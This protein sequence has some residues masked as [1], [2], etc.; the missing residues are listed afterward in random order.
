MRFEILHHARKSNVA[1]SLPDV[2]VRKCVHR[3]FRPAINTLHHNRKGDKYSLIR[4]L[5]QP[6]DGLFPPEGPNQDPEDDQHH[7]LLLPHLQPS[8]HRPG[9][10]HLLRLRP[11]PQRD[12]QC[13]GRRHL[14]RQ[15]RRQPLHLPG[16]PVEEHQREEVLQQPDERVPA[17]SVVHVQPQEGH[18]LLVRLHFVQGAHES[19]ESAIAGEQ[20]LVGRR[21]GEQGGRNFS[22]DRRS[23]NIHYKYTIAC[24]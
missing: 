14:G 13:L 24:Y 23:C 6:T 17:E 10:H 12:V 22:V 16:V 2:R 19:G 3:P 21:Y 20:N 15:Q 5:C 9:D 4:I 7:P 18:V 8:V 1:A 11:P